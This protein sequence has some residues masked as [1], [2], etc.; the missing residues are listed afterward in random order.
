MAPFLS[1]TS[2]LD[3]IDKSSKFTVSTISNNKYDGNSHGNPTSLP[4]LNTTFAPAL[5][6]TSHNALSNH[7]V[8]ASNQPVT[9][10]VEDMLQRFSAFVAAF[11]DTDETCFHAS[12]VDGHSKGE[13]FIV[14][15]VLSK[16]SKDGSSCSFEK[17]RTPGDDQTSSNAFDFGIVIVT[18]TVRQVSHEQPEVRSCLNG[19]RKMS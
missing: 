5:E 8:L 18:S 2:D 12:I 7:H 10:S 3:D 1:P 19:T 13:S 11:A 14:H 6:G 17:L 16:D 4:H 9:G 15:A